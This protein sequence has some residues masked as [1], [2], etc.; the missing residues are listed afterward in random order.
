MNGDKEVFVVSLRN[1]PRSK[2]EILFVEDGWR[3]VDGGD[4]DDIYIVRQ[5]GTDESKAFVRDIRIR[6]AEMGILLNA[7]KT[8]GVS[9]DAK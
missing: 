1:S 7:A 6:G 3:E 2:I 4:G 5:W 9:F 8:M